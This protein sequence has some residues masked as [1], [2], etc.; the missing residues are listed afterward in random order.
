MSG[1]MDIG[2]ATS[3]V[4]SEGMKTVINKIQT[5][6]INKAVDTIKTD[7]D[8]LV[9][10]VDSYWVGQAAE[11]FKM[12]TKEDAVKIQ[13]VLEVIKAKLE[14]D[15]GTMGVNVAAADRAV[16]DAIKSA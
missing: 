13:T 7:V 10:N 9:D 2:Q 3:G 11:A 5:D 14:V 1:P 12:K 8:S 6:L 4:S 15:L 16:S